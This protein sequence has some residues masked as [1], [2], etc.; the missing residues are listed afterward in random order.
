MNHIDILNKSLRTLLF[1]L[2]VKVEEN[3]EDN[4]VKGMLEGVRIADALVNAWEIETNMGN[5]LLEEIST[6][7]TNIGKVKQ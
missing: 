4:Y 5:D 1:N 7:Q 2:S 3:P 6:Y